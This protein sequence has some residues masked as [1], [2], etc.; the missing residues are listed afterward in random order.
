MKVTPSPLLL[1][2]VLVGVFGFCTAVRAQ[3]ASPRV[4]YREEVTM[5]EFMAVLAQMPPAVAQAAQEYRDAYQ[6]R[7]GRPLRVLELRRAFSDGDGD[8]TLMGMITATHRRDE[9]RVRQLA[10]QLTCKGG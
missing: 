8:P 9:A 7:C 6:V 3:V 10:G 4:D 1:A 2:S 5:D